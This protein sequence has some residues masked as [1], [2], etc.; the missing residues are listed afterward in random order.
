MLPNNQIHPPR[1]KQLCWRGLEELARGARVTLGLLHSPPLL[2]NPGDR[3]PLPGVPVQR[4]QQR[5]R[6]LPCFLQYGEMRRVAILPRQRR[7]PLELRHDL[8][9]QH[10]SS[11]LH[12]ARDSP[13]VAVAGALSP[14]LN[15]RN[16]NEQYPNS[17]SSINVQSR[18]QRHVWIPRCVDAT[19]GCPQDG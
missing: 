13:A 17:T 16:L 7:R 6:V 19:A 8:Q 10:P 12:H 1:N 3:R 14:T 15:G 18:R 4:L 5:S 2:R 11:Q 9:Q